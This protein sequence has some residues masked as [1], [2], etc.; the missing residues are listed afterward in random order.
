VGVFF[1]KASV[2]RGDVKDAIQD[3]LEKDPSTVQNKE[4]EAEKKTAEIAPAG[5]GKFNTGRFLGALLIF[6]A[7]VGTAIGTDAASLDDSSVALWG[8]AATI[9]G[10]VVGFLAG[11]KS[12]ATA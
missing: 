3:A 11:E 10:V 4:A 1:E 2:D 5:Y 8:F 9:F 6:A 7:I 12:A